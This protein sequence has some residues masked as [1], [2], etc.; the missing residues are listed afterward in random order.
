MSYVTIIRNTLGCSALKKNKI[1]YN[2][3]VGLLN[4]GF[5]CTAGSFFWFLARPS[6]EHIIFLDISE[7]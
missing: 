5:S 1:L 4:S 3:K 6:Y 7:F 2:P